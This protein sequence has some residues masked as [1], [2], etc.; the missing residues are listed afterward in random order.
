MN[1]NRTL[2]CTGN[3]TDNEQ[4][5]YLCFYMYLLLVINSFFIIK[6]ISGKNRDNKKIINFN[7]ISNFNDIK[8]KWFVSNK[9]N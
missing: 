7:K 6:Y 3:C 9:L 1:F 5:K 8:K 4:I 2:N